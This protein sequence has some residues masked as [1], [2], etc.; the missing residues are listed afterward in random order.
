M[1]DLSKQHRHQTHIYCKHTTTIRLGFMWMCLCLDLS[2]QLYLVL[3]SALGGENQC[4]YPQVHL[5]R[6]M[7]SIIPVKCHDN[8]VWVSPSLATPF[9]R[10]LLKQKHTNISLYSV[11][12]VTAEQRE[13]V[14]LTLTP[15]FLQGEH[16]GNTFLYFNTD[17]NVRTIERFLTSQWNPDVK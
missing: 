5:K 7:V 14:S 17:C 11:Y 4:T 2:T 12:Y 8:T 10:F 13:N 15:M 9:C 1:S 6:K 3:I 16:T